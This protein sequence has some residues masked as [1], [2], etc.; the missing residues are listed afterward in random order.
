MPEHF[1]YYSFTVPYEKVI[2]SNRSSQSD[3]ATKN[4]KQIKFWYILIEFKCLWLAAGNRCFQCDGL[5]EVGL[6]D[7][8]GGLTV[9]GRGGDTR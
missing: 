1:F 9:E 6:L 4:S 2:L 3:V 5:G 7:E 8:V